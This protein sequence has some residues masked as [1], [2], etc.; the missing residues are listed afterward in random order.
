MLVNFCPT[1][2]RHI[3]EDIDLEFSLRLRLRFVILRYSICLE[4]LRKTKEDL[5]QDKSVLDQY[6]SSKLR[7]MK[8]ECY[9]P[10]RGCSELKY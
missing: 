6:F 8:Q 1:T 2:R 4:G 3:Q 7:N 9:Q 5:T 10:E